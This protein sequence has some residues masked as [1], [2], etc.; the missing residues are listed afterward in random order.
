MCR[1]WIAQASL[2]TSVGLTGVM[3]GLATAGRHLV[4]SRVSFWAIGV[5]ALMLLV[6]VWHARR[7]RFPLLE[8]RLFGFDTFS[9]G[10]VGVL[11]FGSVSA[12]FRFCC[13]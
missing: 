4:S 2:L 8:L 10:V 5:G 13:R 1:R 6:Y 7:T 3:L 11:C 9:A 12:R